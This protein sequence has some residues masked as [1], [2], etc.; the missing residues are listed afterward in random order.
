MESIFEIVGEQMDFITKSIRE[1]Q[2]SEEIADCHASSDDGCEH[3][4]K[5]N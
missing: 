1:S 3:C 4:E 5:S 2:K